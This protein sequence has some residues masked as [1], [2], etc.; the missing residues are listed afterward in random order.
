MAQRLARSQ[1]CD[2]DVAHVL[3]GATQDRGEIM[4]DKP[5]GPGAPAVAGPDASLSRSFTIVTR[6]AAAV[7]TVLGAAVLVAWAAHV[8][9]IKNPLGNLRM[10]PNTALMFVMSGLALA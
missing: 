6:A 7:T 1:K 2:S 9:W 3:R 8:E 10:A 5:A 4:G